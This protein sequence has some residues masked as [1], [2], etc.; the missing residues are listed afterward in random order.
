M[1]APV[2]VPSTADP[3]SVQ[4]VLA[5]AGVDAAAGPSVGWTGYL[6]AL[7]EAVF[8]S[9]REVGEPLNALLVAYGWLAWVVACVL[10][11]VV[12]AWLV[13]LVLRLVR[14]RQ[15][16]PRGAVGREAILAAEAPAAR[17]DAVEWRRELERRLD[18]GD[19]TGTLEAAWWWF[20]STATGRDDLSRSCT[21]REVVTRAGRR[22]LAASAGELDR[23]LYGPHRPGREELRALVGRLDRVLS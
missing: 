15:A 1:S 21:S 9:L 7:A 11:A 6:E 2:L 13:I 8:G 22:D 12:V 4:R 10:L 19:L 18:A 17:R 16:P 20:A 3:V 5:E 14:D 23:F